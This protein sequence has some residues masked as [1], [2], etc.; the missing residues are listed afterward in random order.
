M[1]TTSEFSDTNNT[2]SVNIFADMR[3]EL[4]QKF[5]EFDS[6]LK[7]HKNTLQ[8]K[9]DKLEL[10]FNNK[11][12]QI[13]KDKQILTELHQQ[14]E[15][16][17]AQESLV[18]L[19]G[20]ILQEIDEKMKNLNLECGQQTEMRFTLYWNQEDIAGTIHSIEIELAPF[21]AT[22]QTESPQKSLDP[23]EDPYPP[24]NN[25]P[26]QQD[27]PVYYDNYPSW[28]GQY[29]GDRKENRGH[30]GR[31]RDKYAYDNSY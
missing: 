2:K 3:T 6:L 27:P 20:K 8:L 26:T 12:K 23:P 4:D 22:N 19:Q 10:E 14:T 28:S 21:K 29:R 25:Y 5:A 7:E 31:Y 13:E 18:D 1:A 9:I 16:N 11:H 17:L 15:S 30:R 24:P